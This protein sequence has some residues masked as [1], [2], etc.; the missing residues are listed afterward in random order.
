LA[1]SEGVSS[2][3]GRVVVLPWLRQVGCSF[4]GLRAGCEF[5]V[6]SGRRRHA[7]LVVS[8]V[9]GGAVPSGGWDWH[10]F[11]GLGEFAFL[12]IMPQVLSVVK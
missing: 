2:E 11:V 5:V 3:V 4:Y 8:F 10:L 7:A 9:P 12:L 1:P 6:V